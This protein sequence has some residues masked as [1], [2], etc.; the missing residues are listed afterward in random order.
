MKLTA[1]VS[2]WI[3][4]LRWEDLP[5]DVIQLAKTCFQDYLGCTAGGARSTSGQISTKAALGWGGPNEATI[6]GASPKVAARNAAFA[7]GM[8]SNA[9]DFDDTLFGHPGSTTFSASLAAAEKWGANGKEFLL[10][11]IIGYEISA[12]AAALMTPIIPRYTAIWDSGTVQAYGAAAAAA[13]LARLDEK[14]TENALG[15]ISATAPVPRPRKIRYLGE[16]RPMIKACYGWAA[17][18]AVV[19]AEMTFGGMTGPGHVFENHM[20]FW[21]MTPSV[22]LGISDIA[23]KLGEQWSIRQ[24]S[25]KPYMSCRFIHPVLQGVEELM[26]QTSISPVEIKAVEVSSFSLLADEH[27]YI[28]RPV[29]ITDAQFSVPYTLAAMLRQGAVTP[30]SY[31]D[32]NL[33][34]P[35]VLS[36]MDKVTV[37]VDPEYDLAYPKTLGAGVKIFLKDGRTEEIRVDNPKGS[38]DNPMT[39]AELYAKFESL[40]APV[41]SLKKTSEIAR[42]INEIEKLSDM[43]LLTKLF[44]ASN[45]AER[46]KNRGVA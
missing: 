34:D 18:A 42:Q 30:D 24:V 44:A 35:E 8:M 3:A 31:A 29:S 7:N 46:L 5:D 23:D 16:G 45:H 38:P 10:A 33:V 6:I 22:E 26:R 20:G 40:A 1:V 28:L 39:G 11:A 4:S 25:F 21:K 2:D 9:L 37:K 14:G 12:R 36:F 13:R 41:L 43:S 15:M 27:H 17:E 19:A 32:K